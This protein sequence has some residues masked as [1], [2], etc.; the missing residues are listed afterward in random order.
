MQLEDL[1]AIPEKTEHTIEQL[2]KKLASMEKDREK[3]EA[4]L[5]E[6]MESLKTETQ[7]LKFCIG[8]IGIFL[9]N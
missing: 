3:E 9:K 2:E 1:K 5:K 6:V 4:K 7:V 8:E